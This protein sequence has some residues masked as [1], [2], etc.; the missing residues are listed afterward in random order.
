MKKRL[1]LILFEKGFFETKNAAAAA[2]L[3]GNVK[4]GENV[5]TKAGELFDEEKLFSEE[6]KN[7][8]SVKVM[9]F[10]SRGGLKLHHAIKEFN[11]N[12]KDRI[13]I[14]MGASTGGFTD[15]MLQEGAKCVYAVDVGYNQLA[16]KLREDKRVTVIEKTNVKNCSFSD[17]FKK[18]SLSDDEMPEFMSMDLSFISIK[19]V[20][21]N[22]LNFIKNDSLMVFLIKP[23]FEAEK[24]EIQKG[25]VVKDEKVHKKIIESIKEYAQNLNLETVGVITSPIQGAKQGNTEYLICLKRGK[26]LC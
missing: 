26:G 25:G 3:A 9:P 14:D 7:K 2:I 15:C 18:E 12:L 8:I 16:W 11:I 4:I 21:Q 6:N 19:K 10:V 13:C 5:L 20:L 17:I 22:V 23:Q 1:D 24:D